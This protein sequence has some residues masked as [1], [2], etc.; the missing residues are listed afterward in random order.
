MPKTYDRE[1]TKTPHNIQI[2]PPFLSTTGILQHDS[3]HAEITVR[4]LTYGNSDYQFFGYRILHWS[5]PTSKIS[6]VQLKSFFISDFY[7]KQEIRTMTEVFLNLTEVFLTPTEVFPCFFLSCKANARVK[8][9]K[10]GQGPHSST[11]VV[12]YLVRLF[13][14]FYVL[15]VCVNVYCHRVATQLQLTN[16][17]QYTFTPSSTLA[18]CEF[19]EEFNVRIEKR[20]LLETSMHEHKENANWRL[21]C[22][23]T[24]KTLTGDFNARTV[25]KR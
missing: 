2:F 24:K 7:S 19:N 18:W 25:T 12:I 8:L 11:L 1:I 14:L 16:I 13:V 15:C 21:K 9:A 22:T 6:E 17:I 3:L 4:I 10:T 20:T 5:K 23:H